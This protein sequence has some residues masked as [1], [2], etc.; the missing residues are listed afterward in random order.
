MT[1]LSSPGEAAILDRW[2]TLGGWRRSVTQTLDGVHQGGQAHE[3]E[4]YQPPVLELRDRGLVDA[5][6]LLELTL[7]E[8]GAMPCPTQGLADQA[9]PVLDRWRLTLRGIRVVAESDEAG[10]RH[11]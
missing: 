9:E 11:R 4:R 3:P 5:G 10:S 8:T 7:A 1:M 2:R 6:H